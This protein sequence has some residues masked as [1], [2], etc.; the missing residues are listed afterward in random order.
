MTSFLIHLD[1]E[2]NYADLLPQVSFTGAGLQNTPSFSNFQ[3]GRFPQQEADFNYYVNDGFTITKAKHT[4]KFGV[5]GEH[6]RITTGTGGMSIKA[7][8]GSCL[9]FPSKES[10]KSYA[11]NIRHPERRAIA[12]DLQ[13]GEA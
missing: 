6:D 13:A 8:L 5:Y 10:W 1:P 7:A 3:S 9:D 12:A 11:Y 2:I 4:F